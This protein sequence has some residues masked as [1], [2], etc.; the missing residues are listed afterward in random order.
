MDS[1]PGCRE[2]LSEKGRNWLIPILG[3]KDILGSTTGGHD[4]TV[5]AFP[6]VRH[7]YL[8]RW[9]VRRRQEREQQEHRQGTPPTMPR[10][11]KEHTN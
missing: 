8:C 7:H 2:K 9:G 6:T 4:L 1:V 5:K 10:S 11:A 3:A